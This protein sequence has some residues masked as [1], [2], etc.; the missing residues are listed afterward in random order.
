MKLIHC[1]KCHD[2][3]RLIHTK[4]RMCECKLTGGQYNADLMSATIGG[5]A[6]V[7]GIPNPF[8]DEINKYLIE[9]NGG[10]QFFRTSKGWGTQDLWYG[11]GAGDLQ[12][13]RIS[14]P[15]GPRL[16]MKVEVVDKNHT[17]SIITD[18]RDYLIDGKKL[19][20]VIIENQMHPSF[21]Q[22]KKKITKSN[23]KVKSKK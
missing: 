2:V 4:W 19:P 21:K 5:D 14:S 15:K 7:L 10:K 1:K 23:G 22:P 9:E 20:F 12:V 3:V 16:S 17:K 11:G 13:H 8:F 6:D 18:K